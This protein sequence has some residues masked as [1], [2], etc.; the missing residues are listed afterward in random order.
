ME[1]EK[2]VSLGASVSEKK[3]SM[4]STNVEG[5]KVDVYLISEEAVEGE[6]LAK[7]LNSSGM[8]IGRAKQILALAKDDAK[9]FSFSFDSNLDSDNVDFPNTYS[10]LLF[11]AFPQ[12]VTFLESFY[13][14]FIRGCKN[15]FEILYSIHLATEE[16][17]D[18]RMA[19][20]RTGG[21]G[22]LENR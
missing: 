18:G 15:S 9:L 21:R 14:V 17:K 5:L 13:F 11:Y 8:E 16:R 19:S 10:L 2:T 1:K 7:A 20:G 3:I 12:E 22:G 4:T 6:L